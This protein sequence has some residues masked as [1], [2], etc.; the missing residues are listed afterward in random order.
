MGEGRC[1]WF[2]SRSGDGYIKGSG[3]GVCGSFGV[4]VS[5][6]MWFHEKRVMDEIVV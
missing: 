1:R 5:S 3:S 4:T 6:Q 2:N